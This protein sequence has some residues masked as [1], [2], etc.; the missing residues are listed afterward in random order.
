MKLLDKKIIVALLDFNYKLEFETAY[1]IHV[2]LKYKNAENR[3][4]LEKEIQNYLQ[5]TN[6]GYLNGI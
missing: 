1:C 3:H 2:K 5:I 6:K 4:I